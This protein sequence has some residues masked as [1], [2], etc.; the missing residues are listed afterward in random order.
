MR[1][2]QVPL[3]KRKGFG[4]IAAARHRAPAA[5]ATA[6]I[7]EKHLAAVVGFADAK[8]RCAGDE[9][10]DRGAGDG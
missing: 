1:T 6:R 9:Q 2:A 5:S 8:V 4:A 3:P 10:F 7:V